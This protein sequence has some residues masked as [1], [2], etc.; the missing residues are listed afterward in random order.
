M[1]AGVDAARAFGCDTYVTFDGMSRGFFISSTVGKEIA[2]SFD[3]G[4]GVRETMWI[5]PPSATGLSDATLGGI[6]AKMTDK[7]WEPEGALKEFLEKEQ[8]IAQQEAEFTVQEKNAL[9]IYLESARYMLARIEQTDYVKE[10]GIDKDFVKQTITEL[11]EK[12]WEKFVKDIR[13]GKKI[14][15]EN[16]EKAIALMQDKIEH[17]L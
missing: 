16:P 11:K 15:P 4:K 12:F 9:R 17:R 3:H 10:C 5:Q 1:P 14:S 6:L 8:K 13:N 2:D 7:G